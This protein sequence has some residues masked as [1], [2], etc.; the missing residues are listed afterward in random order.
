MSIEPRTLRQRLEEIAERKK[1]AQLTTYGRFSDAD[2]E[3]LQKA[4]AEDPDNLQIREMAAFSFYSSNRL[5]EAVATYED[6]IRTHPK[7]YNY[8]YYLANSFAKLGEHET[9][10]QNWEIVAGGTDAAIAKK[11]RARIEET[12]KLLKK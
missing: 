4:L 1:D 6:L 5:Q 8:Y 2:L 7:V 12:R 10:I 11:S 9:A 3:S